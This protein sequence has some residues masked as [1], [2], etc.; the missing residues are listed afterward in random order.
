M[1]GVNELTSSLLCYI[2]IM[3]S[4]SRR[5]ERQ[6]RR[7]LGKKIRKK[8]GKI[9]QNISCVFSSVIPVVYLRTMW[10]NTYRKGSQKHNFNRNIQGVSVYTNVSANYMFR[11]LLVKPSS[12]WIPWSEE[13]YNS[14]IQPLKSGRDKIYCIFPLTK[15]S[16]LKMV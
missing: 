10:T 8:E 9:V 14:A 16:N 7:K 13:I 2:V 3:K 12:G 11:P 1:I 6:R 15:V 4:Y 5:K